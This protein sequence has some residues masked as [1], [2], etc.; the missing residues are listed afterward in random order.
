[1]GVDIKDGGSVQDLRGKISSLHA[2]P[3]DIGST[4]IQFWI[5]SSNNDGRLDGESLSYMSIE[6]AALLI[7]ELKQAI[8]ITLD[9]IGDS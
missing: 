8:Q 7:K 1:M 2:L 3:S 9:K 5:K 4:N 6:E